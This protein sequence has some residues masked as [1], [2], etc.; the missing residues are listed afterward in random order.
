MKHGR[1]KQSPYQG[2]TSGNR[3]Y[4]PGHRPSPDVEAQWWCVLVV[5][6]V[7]CVL[8]MLCFRVCVRDVDVGCHGMRGRED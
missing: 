3:R 1:A 8:R 2:S 7:L 6:D 4:R 5:V